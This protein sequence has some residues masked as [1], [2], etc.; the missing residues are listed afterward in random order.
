MIR[1]AIVASWMLLAG[2][3]VAGEPFVIR[4]VDEHTQ[5]GVPL[6]ELKTTHNVRY[7]TDNSGLVAIDDPGL[8]G[9]DVFFFVQSHGYEFP[10]DGFGN[11]GKRF[12]VAAGKTAEVKLKR[13]NLAERLY[14]VTGADLYQHTLG[15]GKRAPIDKPR[16]NAQV[17]GCDGAQ[18]ALYGGTL[19]WT[20]GDTSRLSYPLGN[21]NGSAAVSR[22]PKQGGLDPAIGINLEYFENE[23]GFA[24]EIAPIAGEGPTWLTALVSVKDEKNQEHLVAAY[25]KIKPPLTVYERGLCEFDPKAERF[26][27]LFAFEKTAALV[28]SGHA[29]RHPDAKGKWLY[30]GEAVPHLRLS[31]RYESLIDPRQYEPI[32]S[33]VRFTNV[34]TGKPVKHHHGAVAWSPYRKKWISI[35]TQEHGETSYLGEIYYAE[36]DAPAGPWRKAVKI[37]THD[38]YSFYNPKQHPY[39]SDGDGR[40]LY[41]EGTYSVMFSR[42]DDPTPLYD[43][44][45]LMYRLDLSDRR[46]RSMQD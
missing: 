15:A 41:F 38:R 23:D 33:D 1:K 2:S 26:N 3:V 35:F 37:V 9:Q 24:Q 17:V 46:L 32:N 40:Y 14:R 45:Q 25:N 7:Y 30:F 36:A 12:R 28:P 16:L 42:N 6:V 10:K 31:D 8:L 21:F 29:F 34:A 13:L 39:F 44:N 4:I 27:K 18:T 20:W 22:L 5:R 43:Y 19:F 11:R